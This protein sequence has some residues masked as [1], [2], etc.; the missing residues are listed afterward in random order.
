MPADWGL[1]G[2]ALGRGP[3][4]STLADA[5]VLFAVSSKQPLNPTRFSRL[6]AVFGSS[7]WAYENFACADGEIASCK[8]T[9]ALKQTYP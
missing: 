9:S 6:A 8:A 7:A 1:I 3:D 4:V 5:S 2:V